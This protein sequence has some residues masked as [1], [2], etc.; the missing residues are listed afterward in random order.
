M[1]LKVEGIPQRESGEDKKRDALMDAMKKRGEDPTMLPKT[2]ATVIAYGR[3]GGGKSSIMYSWLKNMFPHYY[4]EVLI[5][6]GSSDSKAA[7]ESLPQKKVVFMTDYDD[8]SFSKYIDKLKEDQNERM[9]KKERPLN[10][11]IGFDDVVFAEAISSRGKPTMAER[12]ILISRHE[13]NATV[14]IC[15]QHSKQVN[16]AM[17][18]NTIYNVILPLQKNDLIKVAEEHAGHLSTEEFLRMY[19]HIMRKG[20]HQFIT[21]DYKAPEER[22]FRE[23]WDKI[24]TFTKDG[25]SKSRTETT[26]G[27]SLPGPGKPTDEKPASKKSDDSKTTTGG[28]R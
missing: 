25:A 11:F 18:N 17:R 10:I 23:K 7:F 24:V 14:F 1:S 4:D 28:S 16:S 3:I 8:E 26:P 13:L 5:F 12:V 27:P 22:R 15:V 21:V 6:C 2:P 20:P 19:Y 9:K